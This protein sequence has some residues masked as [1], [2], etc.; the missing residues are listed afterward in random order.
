MYGKQLLNKY[1]KTYPES[2][3]NIKQ[4]I[5][6]A[7]AFLP[8]AVAPDFAQITPEGDSLNLSDLRGKVV[9]VDFWAS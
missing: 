7:G 5:Q 8:G 4:K 1:E 6:F 3:K 9:L 2:I